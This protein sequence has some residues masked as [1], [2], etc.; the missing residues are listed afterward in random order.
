MKTLLQTLTLFC[1]LLFVALS[2]A[3]AAS[4]IEPG[5]HPELDE[6]M[7]RHGRQ[8]YEI[9]ARPFGLSLDAHAKDSAAREAIETFLAQDLSDDFEEVTGFHPFE[10]LSSYGEYGDLGF[11]GGVALAGT[12]YEYMTLKR[13]G[14][15]SEELARARA[16]VV[17]AAETWHIFYV[18][19]GGN[20]IVAR[21]VQRNTPEDPDDPPIP[22]PERDLVPLFDENGDPLPQPKNNGAY[23]D[24]NSNGVLPEGVWWWKD[25]CS[26]DQLVG[27]VFA[28]SAMYDAMKD[29]PDIDQSLVARMQ[30]DARL[31]GQSLMELRDISKL[32]GANISGM[33]DLIIMDADGRPTM[34]HDLNPL[35]LEKYYMSETAGKFNLFNL[36]MAHGVIKG[37]HHISGDPELE[38]YYYAELLHNRDYL[39]KIVKAIEDDPAVL[40]Y[41]YMGTETNFD[42]P[43]MTAVALWIAIYLEND[44]EVTSVLRRFLEEKWWDRPGELHTARLTKQP[45]WSMIYMTLTDQGVGRELVDETV[46][47]LL[48]FDLGPYWNDAR[49][50]CEAGEII[51]KECLAI[52]GETV[53]TLS[54]IMGENQAMATEALHPSIRPPSNFNSR[55]NPFEVNGGG[56]M[57]LNPGGDILAAYWIGRYMQANETGEVNVS[58]FARTHMPVGGYAADGDAEIE[59]TPDTTPPDGSNSGGGG[60]DD[61][62]FTAGASDNGWTVSLLLLLLAAWRRTGMPNAK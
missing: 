12:A 40:D 39:G 23:R 8:F 58:H 6:M 9:N 2:V 5:D 57:R 42:N 30:E 11:F 27:Q 21:G 25:S 15:S 61:G 56:G 55:S 62:C 19:T 43:D 48:G 50:N 29:D 33:Y 3:D 47:L 17:H 45:F 28:M 53:L 59:E 41:I 20:G 46:D 10:I 60:N 18:V 26:K 52:D 35:S 16:R 22:N 44:P 4:I 32:E 24:D 1:L 37:L 31:V 34:Y 54:R 13:D 7:K 36:I 49:V 51:A 14:A 38:E